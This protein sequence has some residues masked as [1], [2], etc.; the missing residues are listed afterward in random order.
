MQIVFLMFVSL[1]GF[2]SDWVEVSHR[3]DGEKFLYLKGSFEKLG[4]NMLHG[5]TASTYVK[6]GSTER[7]TQIDCND[8][9]IG[10]GYTTSHNPN[11]AD[12]FFD[13]SKNGWVFFKTIDSAEEKLVKTLCKRYYKK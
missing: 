2:A 7:E 5:Y 10:Y 8:F 6:Q 9:T 3:S 11:A 13:A 1:V 12:F 4:N